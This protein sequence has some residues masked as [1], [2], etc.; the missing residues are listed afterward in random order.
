[1]R[2]DV[3][4]HGPAHFIVREQEVESNCRG[5]CACPG[6]LSMTYRLFGDILGTNFRMFFINRGL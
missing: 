5:S 2:V 4:G 6:P 3:T 1:M